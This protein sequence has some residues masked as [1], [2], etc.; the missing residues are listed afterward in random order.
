VSH[1][2]IYGGYARGMT[3]RASYD[4][5]EDRALLTLMRKGWGRETPAF[6]QVFT[7][8]F[9]REDTEPEVLA[10]FN[11]MQRA[12][13]DPDTAARYLASCHSR[14]DGTALFSQVSTPTLVVH[15]RDDRSVSFE[16]GRYLASVTPGAEF[17]PLAGSAH[18]FPTGPAMADEPG[19]VDLADAVSSFVGR[20]MPRE[21]ARSTHPSRGHVP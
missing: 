8:Q 17:L 18:Y 14:H 2:V 9:F 1:L 4:P 12:S 16:E 19:A 3:S 11:E 5:E 15:R 20:T 21:P 10:H 13:A 6:R 7:S